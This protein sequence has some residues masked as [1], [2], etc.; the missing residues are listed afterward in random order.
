[1]IIWASLI[2]FILFLRLMI[3]L[4]TRKSQLTFLIL[5]GIAIV[6]IM[7]LRFP[8]YNIEYDVE[9]Y[10][11]YYKTLI[12][13]PLSQIFQV[14]RFEWGYVI[15]NK[16]L[17]VLIPFPQFVLF[18]EAA[19]CTF[20]VFRFIYLYSD[21]I[22]MSV[23]FYI[24]LGT[25]TFFLT[26]FRQ[27]FAIGLCLWSIDYLKNRKPFKFFLVVLT[28]CFFH[29]TAVVFFPMYYIFDRRP[30]RFNNIVSVVAILCATFFAAPLTK[31]GTSLLNMKYDIGY[32][33]NSWG[34][35]VP[36]IIYSITIVFLWLNKYNRDNYK[37]ELNMTEVGLGIYAMRYV[38]ISLERV[39]FFFTTGVVVSLPRAINCFKDDSTR[40]LIKLC[41]IILAI[42]LFF[43]R[44]GYSSWG[45]YK[46]F[47]QQ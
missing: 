45:N 35:T 23:L 46:F 1:M 15:L 29:K 13:T 4:K 17:A 31:W 11:N 44:A 5:S 40:R 3:N 2:G 6:L 41:A 34:G 14:D 12:N 19:F 18:F 47:W 9:I 20:F 24:T 28:A 43:Y 21:D 26:A 32:I 33:G 38:T 36:I 10:Y 7:G 42:I 37:I 22:F 39:S 8:K 16:I 25:M 27:A 30:T